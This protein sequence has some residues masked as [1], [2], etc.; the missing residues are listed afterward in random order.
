[1]FVRRATSSIISQQSTRPRLSTPKCVTR[2]LHGSHKLYSHAT[3]QGPE[4]AL[5]E[6]YKESCK[7]LKL[8]HLKG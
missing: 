5:F 8:V 2:N 4:I 7:L 1:M 3:I 6:S